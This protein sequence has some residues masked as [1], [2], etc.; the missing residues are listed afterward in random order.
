MRVF[1]KRVVRG[2]F[3]PKRD[4]VTRGWRKMH[5]EKLYNLYS[6]PNIIRMKKSRMRWVK[7][8]AYIRGMTNP[9]KILV[10]KPDGKRQLGRTNV[11]GRIPLKYILGKY[12]WGMDRIHM[13]Q[14]WDQWHALV[15]TVMDI[16]VPWNVREV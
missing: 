13:A 15:N 7:H 5:N 4:K 6:S 11:H 1:Q 9:Y 3:R 2:I 8:A 12:G 10:R 14:E 16:R